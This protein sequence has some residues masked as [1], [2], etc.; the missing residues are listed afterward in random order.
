MCAR[1]WAS[2][3]KK[4]GGASAVS[5]RSVREGVGRDDRPGLAASNQVGGPAITCTSNQEGEEE[6]QKK[7]QLF[8]ALQA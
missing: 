6:E 4:P 8:I 3:K 2:M 1:R 7:R 5:R